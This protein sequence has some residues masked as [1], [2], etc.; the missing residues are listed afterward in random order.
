ML[1]VIAK[2]PVI[3]DFFRIFF[4]FTTMVEIYEKRG[5][6]LIKKKDWARRKINK[7]L[8]TFKILYE[9]ASIEPPKY[10]NY[11]IT[12]NGKELLM[13]YKPSGGMFATFEPVAFK[14][15]KERNGMIVTLD[16]LDM[17]IHDKD[18]LFW[19]NQEQRR[20]RERF[21]KQKWYEVYAPYIV[22]AVAGILMVLM[23]STTSKN[24]TLMSNNLR[25]VADA[26][27]AAAET[28]SSATSNLPTAPP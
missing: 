5:D 22:L 7:G 6:A 11:V 9:N 1:D 19:Y 12:K 2:I 3:G 14:T 20:N 25:G 17:T 28:F 21:F 16:G 15:K 23:I 18:I 4:G 24:L 26:I 8:E 13:L 10:K 27:Q